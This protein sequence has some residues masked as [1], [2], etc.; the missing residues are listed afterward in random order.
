[1]FFEVRYHILFFRLS[2]TYQKGCRAQTGIISA[3][4]RQS[5]WRDAIQLL[6][7]GGAEIQVNLLG[8]SGCSCKTWGA[9]N[10]PTKP[11]FGDLGFVER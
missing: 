4:E 7:V 5:R 10:A 9:Q 3:C 11:W 8:S 2:I 1:M 6:Q